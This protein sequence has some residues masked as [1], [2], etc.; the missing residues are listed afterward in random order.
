MGKLM[1]NPFISSSVFAFL[2]ASRVE[3]MFK[4]LRKYSSCS[5]YM[6]IFER[7]LIAR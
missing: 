3:I 2:R 5:F 7:L 1:R 6:E 4:N